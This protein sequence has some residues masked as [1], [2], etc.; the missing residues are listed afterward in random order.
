MSEYNPHPFFMR[1]EI[2]TDIFIAGFKNSGNWEEITI[3]TV[4]ENFFVAIMENKLIVHAGNI[5]IDNTTIKGLIEEYFSEDNPK[6]LSYF[7]AFTSKI[8]YFSE[9]NFSNRGAIALYLKLGPDQNN[10]IAMFRKT[11]MLIR[12]RQFRSPLKFSGVFIASGDDINKLLRK[13]E[14]PKHDNWIASR[15]KE[16][17]ASKVLSDMYD[18]ISDQ[19]K[20]LV[21]KNTGDTLDL[22]GISQYLADDND[23]IIL[24]STGNVLDTNYNAPE[25]IIIRPKKNISKEEAT[26][27]VQEEHMTGTE[28]PMN[29]F[30]VPDRGKHGGASTNGGDNEGENGRGKGAGHG[31]GSGGRGEKERRTGGNSNSQPN[32]EGEKIQS[33]TTLPKLK[34]QLPYYRSGKYYIVLVPE[35]DGQA[36]LGLLFEGEESSEQA[37]IVSAKNKVTGEVIDVHGQMKIGPIVMKANQQYT[38]ELSLVDPEKRAIRVKLYAN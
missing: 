19:I 18:W 25:S 28:D 35:T 11:G 38:V 27:I 3:K 4:V 23:D 20:T 16:R 9:A 26:Y 1:E 21:R 36:Y 10:T 12:E 29:D 37:K 30:D 24:S 32:P 5:V 22:E 31:S 8:I 6:L 34:K 13:M 33:I 17:G 2:G 7:E 15:A 14:P